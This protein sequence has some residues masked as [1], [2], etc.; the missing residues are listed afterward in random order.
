MLYKFIRNTGGP[1][2]GS[3]LLQATKRFATTRRVGGNPDPADAGGNPNPA[4]SGGNPD[5]SGAGGNPNPKGVPLANQQLMDKVQAI[6]LRIDFGKLSRYAR[7][8][9]LLSAICTEV[10]SLRGK[11]ESYSQQYYTILR[12]ENTGLQEAQLQDLLESMES[13]QWER[14][15]RN[16]EAEFGDSIEDATKLRDKPL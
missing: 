5:P 10:R 2:I 9:D 15:L 12:E 3:P 16:L 11:K 13:W 7:V 4:D 6:M 1:L 8:R 14:K